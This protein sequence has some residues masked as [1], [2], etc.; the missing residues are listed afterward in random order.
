MKHYSYTKSVGEANSTHLQPE[1][2][3]LLS[4]PSLTVLTYSA[5]KH[6]SVV[7]YCV[8]LLFRGHHSRSS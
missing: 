6:I 4:A 7:L 1:L 2:K 5:V 3:A 8:P